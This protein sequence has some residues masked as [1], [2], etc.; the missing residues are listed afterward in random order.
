M[1]NMP[2]SYENTDVQMY[3][4]PERTSILAILSLVMG[5]L[6]CCTFF[7]APIGMLLGIFGLIGISKSEGRVGGKGLAIAGLVVSFL[8]FVIWG[9]IYYGAN[10]ARHYYVTQVGG[11]IEAILIDIHNGNYDNARSLMLPP[12]SATSDAELASFYAAY[13]ADLGEFIALPDGF[14]ELVSGSLTI[15]QQHQTYNGRPGYIPLPVRF[16]SGWVLVIYVIDPNGQASQSGQI[17]PPQRLILVGSD[18]KEY[19]LPA[20][21]GNTNSVNRPAGEAPADAQEDQTGDDQNADEA[22]EQPT[23]QPGDETPEGP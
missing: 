19:T 15:A 4:E 23:D 21:A 7:T 10:Q 8:S 18:G 17:P 11:P 16:D 2:G 5:V 14:G 9:A 3:Q 6:G 1:S 12:A 22:S 20:D 13:T